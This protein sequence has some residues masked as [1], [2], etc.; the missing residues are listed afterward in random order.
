MSE[1]QSLQGLAS[2][3]LLIGLQL[4][5]PFSCPCGESG[6]LRPLFL[7]CT[8]GKEMPK[9]FIRFLP[10]LVSLSLKTVGLFLRGEV[11]GGTRSFPLAFPS[12][13]LSPKQTQ[14][15]QMVDA[16]NLEPQPRTSQKLP[17]QTPWITTA[18]ICLGG[19]S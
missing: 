7:I 18:N 16:Q 4:L 6:V 9:A 10:A 15:H 14:N 2:L 3:Q 5:Y 1:K 11:G 12:P 19:P 13:T 8:L 17:T